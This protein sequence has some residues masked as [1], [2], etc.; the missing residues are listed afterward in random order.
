MNTVERNEI[1]ELY[2]TSDLRKNVLHWYP[3]SKNCTVLQIGAPSI[4]IV[5]E[6]C[7]KAQKVTLIVNSDEEKKHIEEIKRENLQIKVMPNL[8]I[9]ENNEQY[10]YVTLIGSVEI[11]KDILEEKAY[12]RLEKL[13]QIANKKC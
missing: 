11:Y 8:E 1:E 6:L 3:I 13:L 9:N 12:K 2:K 7:N 10:D 5:E 4:K